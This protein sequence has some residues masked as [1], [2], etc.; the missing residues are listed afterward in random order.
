MRPSRQQDAAPRRRSVSIS[1]EAPHV[2]TENEQ[3]TEHP[4]QEDVAP[5]LEEFVD[6]EE[7]QLWDQLRKIDIPNIEPALPADAAQHPDW[8]APPL[9]EPALT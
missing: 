8:A 4:P 7:D 5:R 2:I 9:A 1:A 6:D 3:R